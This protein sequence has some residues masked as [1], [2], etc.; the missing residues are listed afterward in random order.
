[1]KIYPVASNQIRIELED[2]ELFEKHEG[3]DGLSIT[4]LNGTL[5]AKELNVA[6]ISLVEVWRGQS[7]TLVEGGKR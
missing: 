1:M 6:T 2:G 4:A 5:I 7:V 3:R